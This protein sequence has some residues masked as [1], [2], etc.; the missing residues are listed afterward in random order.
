M[1]VGVSR[2]KPLCTRLRLWQMSPDFWTQEGA[3]VCIMA[4]HLPS[5]WIA[6]FHEGLKPRPSAVAVIVNKKMSFLWD[7]WEIGP[8]LRTYIY[9]INFSIVLYQKVPD[10]MF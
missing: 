8:V 1:D 5:L 10:D 3:F 7:F 4:A 2:Q 9:A 6:L